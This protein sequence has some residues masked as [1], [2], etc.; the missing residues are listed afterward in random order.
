MPIFNFDHAAADFNDN[1]RIDIFDF[2]KIVTH[3]GTGSVNPTP[4]LSPTAAITSPPPPTPTRTPTPTPRPTNTPG[5][6][7]TQS[8][9]QAS[10]S[11]ISAAEVRALPIAGQNGCLTGSL[12]ANAWNAIVSTAN[13]SWGTPD[14][15]RYAGLTHSQGI[16]AGALVAARCANG[17]C[18]GI[19]DAAMRTK[20]LNA[21]SAVIGTEQH[22]L[23]SPVS[24][25]L[26]APPRQ[27]PRYVIAAELMGLTDWGDGYLGANNFV[28]YMANTRFEYPS[29]RMTFAENHNNAPSNGNTMTGFARVITDAYLGNTTDLNNAWITFRRYVGDTTVVKAENF[30]INDAGKTWLFSIADPDG[31]EKSGS[32]NTVGINPA[33]TSCHSTGYPAG[34]AIPAD[35]GRGGNCPS[36][37][38]TPGYTQY[39][40]EGLQGIYAQAEVFRRKGFNVNGQNPF[41][42]QNNALKRAVEYQWYLQSQFG[43]S[44]YDSD[45]AAWV[46]HLANY[47]YAYKP[48][49]YDASDGGR[50]IAFTQW[51]HQ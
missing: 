43:G 48:V 51:T 31:N 1:G 32:P 2:S 26:L 8:P 25:Q 19:N 34:G 38:D 5:P 13:G 46:K 29:G 40:W 10:G 50:N 22:T 12:C 24:G 3:F 37:G 15:S 18:T 20:V 14:L 45:R 47:Y 23:S 9:I 11:W 39:P 6:T 27:F 44:W 36:S 28:A 17:A 7:P 16:Y 41:Q 30:E 4:T 33:N 42:I 49:N 21:L 35:Q